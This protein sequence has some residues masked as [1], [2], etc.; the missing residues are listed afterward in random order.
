MSQDD[1]LVKVHLDL[2][3]HW[4]FKGESLWARPLGGDL[5]EIQNVPFCAYGLNCRDVVRAVP[6]NADEKPE[7]REVVRRSG[8]RTLRISFHELTKT[9]QS[10]LL[11]SLE[12]MGTWV[13]RANDSFVCVNLPPEAD[14]DA[15][16]TFLDGQ[17]TQGVLEYET[18]EERVP[19][20]FDDAPELSQDDIETQRGD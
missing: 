9:Q 16:C 2:P 13:E 4:W 5:Y 17:E 15:V 1:D 14:Y 6:V 20:S 19:G 3:N 8:N 7:V 10:P 12:A 11:D 18:C